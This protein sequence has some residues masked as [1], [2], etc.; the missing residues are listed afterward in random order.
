MREKV[1]ERVRER[2]IDSQRER[3]SEL[4]RAQINR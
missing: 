4:E 1:G 3:E 2:D